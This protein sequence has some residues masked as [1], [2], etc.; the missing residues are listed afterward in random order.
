MEC[1]ILSSREAKPDAGLHAY[2]QYDAS[3]N[4]TYDGRNHDRGRLVE[5]NGVQ[6]IVGGLGQWVAKIQSNDTVY[7]HYDQSRHLIAESDSQG[8]RKKDKK[9]RRRITVALVFVCCGTGRASSLCRCQ[10]IPLTS[11]F[12]LRPG[13]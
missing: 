7:Y 12:R 10:S 3:G 6:Y 9:P 8:S 13:R 4:R 5:A 11:A 1:L 2:C